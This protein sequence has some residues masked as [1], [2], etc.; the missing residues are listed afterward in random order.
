MSKMGRYVVDSQERFGYV[1]PIR[2]QCPELRIQGG[3]G[4]Y[5]YL[6]NLDDCLCD[7]EYYDLICEYYKDFLE[8]VAFWEEKE[9]E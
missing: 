3:K 1:R 4:E 5:Q 7:Y 6:C 2:Q 9:E 8:A